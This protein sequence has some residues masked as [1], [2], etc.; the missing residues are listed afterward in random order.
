MI[1]MMKWIL[2]T[3]FIFIVFATNQIKNKNESVVT[4]ENWTKMF[5]NAVKNGNM[6]SVGLLLLVNEFQKENLM[7]FL[8]KGNNR[9]VTALHL[10]VHRGDE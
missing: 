5:N 8:I 1:N 10:A 9:N 4:N 2:L 3:G 7:E 6:E